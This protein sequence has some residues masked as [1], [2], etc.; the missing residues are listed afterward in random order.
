MIPAPLRQRFGI[1]E[2]TLVLFEEGPDGVVVRPATAIP[3]ETYSAERRAAFLLDNA[4]DD[5][6]YERARAAVRDLGLDP[7]AIPH[8][9]PR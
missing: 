2:G 4:V 3:I 9:R 7:D 6:D 1:E 5:E 8:E